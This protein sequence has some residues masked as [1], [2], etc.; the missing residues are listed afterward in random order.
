MRKDV[1]V[2]IYLRALL[3]VVLVGAFVII[4]LHFPLL[5]SCILLVSWFILMLQLDPPAHWDR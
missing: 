5:T 3:V 2:K 1:K 4:F